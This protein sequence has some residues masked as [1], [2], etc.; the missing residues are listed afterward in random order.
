MITINFNGSD[1]KLEFNRKTVSAMEDS[2]FVLD[3]DR[4]NTFVD[5]LFYGAFQMHHKKIDRE[6]VRKIWVAQRDKDGLVT[7]LV[8]EYRKPLDELMAEPEG[9]EGTEEE[10][11]IP[12]W[13]QV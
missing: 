12:T 10:N 11:P 2:G 8:K 5:R 6:F 1:Y 3:M 4:P 13:N 7:A 9:P